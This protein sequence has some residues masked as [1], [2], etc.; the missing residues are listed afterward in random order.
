MFH[1]SLVKLPTTTV[2]VPVLETARCLLVLTLWCASWCCLVNSKLVSFV[3]IFPVEGHELENKSRFMYWKYSC[4][5]LK[6]VCFMN[7]AVETSCFEEFC[8][9]QGYQLV[10]TGYSLGAGIATVLSFLLRD[11]Y[12]NLHCYAF[13]PPQIFRFEKRV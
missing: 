1:C 2:S 6:A 11:R 12:P 10:I 4:L 8:V 5:K 13:A 9:L 3:D 7:K